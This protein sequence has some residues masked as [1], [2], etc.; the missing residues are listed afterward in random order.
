MPANSGG[1]ARQNHGWQNHKHNDMTVLTARFEAQDGRTS[2]FKSGEC[3]QGN[4]ELLTTLADQISRS[5]SQI[6]LTR[7]LPIFMILP[8]MILQNLR[9]TNR[10]F[11]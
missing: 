9:A 10:R 6:R 11:P 5:H 2:G 7:F 1:V 4:E 8:A 3:C